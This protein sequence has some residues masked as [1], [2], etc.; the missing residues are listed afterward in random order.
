MASCD[1]DVLPVQVCSKPVSP[2]SWAQ[3]PGFPFIP[4]VGLGTVAELQQKQK[5]K[6]PVPPV[7]LPP[8][9]A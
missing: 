5:W 6:G 2:L 3:R 8:T 4:A 9:E 1:G 7:Y